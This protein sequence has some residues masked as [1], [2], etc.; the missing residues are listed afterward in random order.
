MSVLCTAELN[1]QGSRALQQVF[2]RSRHSWG[3]ELASCIIDWYLRS[4]GHTAGRSSMN[5]KLRA[6]CCASTGSH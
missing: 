3:H 5:L 2:W 4:Q 6:A 1:Q